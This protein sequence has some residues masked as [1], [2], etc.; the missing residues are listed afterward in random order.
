MSKRRLFTEKYV[1]RMT[2]RD[3]GLQIFFA[4][5]WIFPEILMLVEDKSMTKYRFWKMQ[6]RS[7]KDSE[8]CRTEI[9]ISSLFNL[10]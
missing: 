10:N 6:D 5:D 9:F 4:T 2:I 7:D 8:I 3:T 1:E